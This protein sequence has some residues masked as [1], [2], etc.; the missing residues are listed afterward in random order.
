MA[1]IF[2]N[3]TDA[4]VGVRCG[5]TTQTIAAHDQYDLSLTFSLPQLA[6]CDQL[7]ELL[8]QGVDTYQLNDGTSDLSVANAVD[9]LRNTSQKLSL[10]AD[11]LLKAA[12]YM[13]SGD[14]VYG[15][16]PNWCDKC[17]W[18]ETAVKVTEETL[19]DSGDGLTFTSAQAWW[20]D[21]QHGR[22]TDEDYL[23]ELAGNRKWDPVVTVDDV[24]KEESKYDKTDKDFLVNYE[25]G[26]VV[27]NSSQAGKTVKATYWYAVSGDWTFAPFAGKKL[28][29]VHVELQFSKNMVLNDTMKFQAYGYAGAFAPQL[30]D[31]QTIF[32][33][34]LV[35]IGKASWY[36]RAADFVNE[37]NGIYPV[38]P[39]WGGS[40]FRGLS[41]DL[42]TFP[43][44]YMTRTD[45]FSAYGM[46]IKVTMETNTPH[47]GQL[48]TVTFYAV[49]RDET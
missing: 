35:P 26:K 21:L 46:C 41:Q 17:T 40:G 22:M 3:K 23:I 19:T 37:A 44:D 9:L 14:K 28:E 13:P 24:V 16:S 31:N 4:E 36:K 38:T 48:G 30:V 34:T 18:Y 7:V 45:L 11:G 33:T 25:D 32:P 29:L 12:T 15:H 2:K 27:F 39:A 43:W 1:R 8:G 49:S 20:V 6:A 47:T 42:L 10:D 5:N